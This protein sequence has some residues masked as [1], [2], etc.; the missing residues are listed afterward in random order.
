[1]SSFGDYE[2]AYLIAFLSSPVFEM[3]V[4]YLASTIDFANESE[5]LSSPNFLNI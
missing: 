1:L 2:K 3:I 4:P 5:Y